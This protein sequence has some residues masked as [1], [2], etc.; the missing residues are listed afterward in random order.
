MLAELLRQPGVEETL[1]LRSSFGFLAIHGGS[2]ERMTDVVARQTAAESGSSYYGVCQPE[3]FRWHLPSTAF[4]PE[5][6]AALSA[7]VEHVD[8]AVAVHGYGREGLWTTLLLGGANRALAGHVAEHLRHALPDYTV[9]AD[10]PAI[11]APLRGVHPANPVNVPTSGGVQL[12]LPPRVRGMGPFWAD[13]EDGLTPH[14]RSL[15]D[16]LVAAATA[17]SPD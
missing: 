15:I 5:Q 17:W 14:T 12:E 7:F 1:E 9:V 10:L 6:S 4:A 11:P 8:V 2:L 3:G 16:G 13:H